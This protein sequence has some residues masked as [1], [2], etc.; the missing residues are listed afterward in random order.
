MQSSVQPESQTRAHPEHQTGEFSAVG[1]IPSCL[2]CPLHLACHCDEQS[3]A[4]Q[5]KPVVVARRTLLRGQALFRTADAFRFAYLIVCGSFKLSRTHPS[6]KEH[7]LAFPAARE[8]LGLDAQS[9]GIYLC[10]AIALEDSQV[11]VV[12]LEGLLSRCRDDQRVQEHFNTLMTRDLEDGRALSMMLSSLS[13]QERIAGFLCRNARHM[14][15]A[16]Y[17]SKE[18]HLRMTREEIGNHLG[19]KL[20]TVSRAL[21]RLHHLKILAVHQ[22]HVEILNVETLQKLAGYEQHQG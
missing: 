5:A 13:A 12:S 15:D 8:V 14:A 3:H 2:A 18:F 11:C 9:G 6:G 17:S 7:I 4:V 20:E 21:S 19:M 10:D 22:R 1:D 16:G